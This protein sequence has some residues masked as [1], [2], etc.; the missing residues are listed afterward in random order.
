MSKDMSE[1]DV[2]RKREWQ[3]KQIDALVSERDDR[4][5]KTKRRRPLWPMGTEKAARA[6]GIAPLTLRNL[7]KQN[8]IGYIQT[9]A[10]PKVRREDLEQCEAL[11][12][13]PVERLEWI[14]E[15]FGPRP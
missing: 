11:C 14:A 4:P 3:R 6:I 13:D 8:Q 12:T 5:R 10:K 1:D 2:V 7:I 9:G 15:A